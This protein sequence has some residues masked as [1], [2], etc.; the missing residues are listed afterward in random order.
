MASRARTVAVLSFERLEIS[1][2][3]FIPVPRNALQT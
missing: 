1:I 2:D 3:P